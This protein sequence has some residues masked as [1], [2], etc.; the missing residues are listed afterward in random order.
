[1]R[2]VNASTGHKREKRAM[3]SGEIETLEILETLETLETLGVLDRLEILDRLGTIGIIETLGQ[4][5]FCKKSGQVLAF[6]VV[7]SA[8]PFPDGA[9]SLR[10][11]SRTLRCVCKGQRHF[12]AKG[13]ALYC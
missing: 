10:I 6:F 9:G 4:V 8:R 3:R 5:E 7:I 11:Y 2:G 1:M 13:Y 12:F